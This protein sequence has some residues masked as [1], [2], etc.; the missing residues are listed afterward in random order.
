MEDGVWKPW[1]HPDYAKPT[2]K[3]GHQGWWRHQGTGNVIA[4]LGDTTSR[5]GKPIVIAAKYNFNSS[6]R[7]N[8][9][10]LLKRNLLRDYVQ[11]SDTLD[12]G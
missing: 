4:V 3:R 10:Q 9:F 2:N 6:A 5:S 11:E 1:R 7:G 12:P 8:G